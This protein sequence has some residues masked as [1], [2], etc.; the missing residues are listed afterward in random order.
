MAFDLLESMSREDL[1]EYIRGLLW[2]FRLVD[3]FWFIKVEEEYGL[4]AAE[5]TNAKVWDKVG[6]LIAR[7]IVKRFGP[8]E[9]GPGQ[10]PIDALLE[11]YR[12]YPWEML[13]QFDMERT[14]PDELLLKM[15]DCPP[16]MGRLK[17]DKGEYACKA[18]HLAEFKGFLKT[19]HPGLRV[20]CFYAP[21]DPHPEDHFCK[22]RIWV[23]RG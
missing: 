6:E 13:T 11:A 10:T 14:G 2:Q 15:S 20:H 7:D 12:Y 17:H 19:I 8:F 22:W 21:P 3:A 5:E 1:L 18:M 9:P 4:S 16:Q 23:E